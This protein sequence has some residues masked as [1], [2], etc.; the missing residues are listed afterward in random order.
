MSIL[1]TTMDNNAL[2]LMR[3]AP[4]REGG[5]YSSYRTMSAPV[6][7]K[8][9]EKLG[10]SIYERDKDT[11]EK[12][13]NPYKRITRRIDS[14]KIRYN[15]RQDIEVNV[16]LVRNLNIIKEISYRSGAILYTQEK[17]ETYFCLGVDTESGNLT[18]F[19]GGVKRG[20]TIIEGGLRELEE[21]SQGVFG[22]MGIEGVK[23]ETV[24]HSYNMAIMFIKV[25]VDRE[26]I[27]ESFKTK[28][29]ENPSPEV[30]DILW[31]S[32]SD[33]LESIHGRGKKLYIRVRKLLSR[34][35]STIT[36]L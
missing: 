20:E 4:M 24:F 17:G 36:E 26:K 30:C 29:R 13:Y 23:D 8:L 33:L 7:G 21:E 27:L 11:K 28:I 35:T 10:D 22:K 16:S 2:S 14:M 19:G 1:K 12:D 15:K 6:L 5:S 34:V 25:N 31:M 3:S 9:G 18:D 32:K